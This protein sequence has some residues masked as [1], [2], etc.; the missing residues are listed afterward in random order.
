MKVLAKDAKAGQWYQDND[1]TRFLCCDG[2][3][4][5]T[6]EGE[7]WNAYIDKEL[8][9]LPDCDGWDWQP[10]KPEKKYRPFAN[11]A[12]YMPHRDAWAITFNRIQLRITMFDEMGVWHDG[13]EDRLVW[14]EVFRD[15]KFDDGTPFGVEV[16]E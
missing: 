1:G 15:L 11:A 12:E 6:P 13:T 9:H 2:R 5:W 8:T 10:P 14:S 4:L 7:T 16:T 3:R